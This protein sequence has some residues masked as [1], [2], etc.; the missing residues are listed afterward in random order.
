MLG[1]LSDSDFE[2]EL[3]NLSGKSSD[4]VVLP[5]LV[6]RGPI[7]EK[8]EMVRQ[9]LAETALEGNTSKDVARAFGVSPQAVNAYRNGATSCATYNQP[10]LNLNQAVN[11]KKLATKELAHQRIVD[12]LTAITPAKISE[13]GLKTQASV[14][15]D[16]SVVYKNLIDEP[17]EKQQNV[18]FVI[19]APQIKTEDD[20]NPAIRVDE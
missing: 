13:A 15:R 7:K 1:L 6:G 14:A 8:P 18:Q 4:G 19:F 16:M 20:Y 10:D 12:A 2:I 11:N 9:L 17:D 5:R 3:L